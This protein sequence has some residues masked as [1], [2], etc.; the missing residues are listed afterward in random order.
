MHTEARGLVVHVVPDAKADDAELDDLT[1]QL[2]EEL[3]Q[4]GARLEDLPGGAVPAR[5]RG[6]ELAAVGGFL[7]KLGPGAAKAL[8]GTIGD[9]VRRSSARAV[10]VEIDGQRL[11][12][13][14][15][16]RA[17]QEQIVAAWLR[18]VESASE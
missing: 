3:E 14:R 12:L 1:R 10:E 9:W 11:R 7:V 5:A 15:A 17:E 16:S 8:I 18:S 2:R 6:L 4:A 13:D